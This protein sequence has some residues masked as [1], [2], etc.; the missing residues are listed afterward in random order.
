MTRA[1]R[2][3]LCLVADDDVPQHRGSAAP[4][5]GVAG[6]ILAIVSIWWFAYRPRRRRGA[7]DTS[8]PE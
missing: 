6:A 2:P 8:A 5:L 3:N 4:K 7:A 1:T